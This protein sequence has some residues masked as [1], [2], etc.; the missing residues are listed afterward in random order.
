MDFFRRRRE[1][2]EPDA[3]RAALWHV[4][5]GEIPRLD[6]AVRRV[7][8]LERH[9]PSTCAFGFARPPEP[10]TFGFVDDVARSTTDAFLADPAIVAGPCERAR[11]SAHRFRDALVTTCTKFSI[12]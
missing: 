9:G 6:D 1:W 11:W 8:F 2:F 12:R 4:R 7:E 10:V 3:Q 5:E